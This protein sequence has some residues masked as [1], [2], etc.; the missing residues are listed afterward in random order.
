MYVL[1]KNRKKMR[2]EKVIFEN[3][4]HMAHVCAR[5]AVRVTGLIVSYFLGG[6]L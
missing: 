3:D 2:K 6:R 5:H 1:D 4:S